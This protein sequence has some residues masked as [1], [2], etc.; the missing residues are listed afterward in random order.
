M[1]IPESH[2]DLLE[3]AA[4][5]HVATI[6][7]DGEPQSSPVWCGTDDE[8]HVIFSMLARRQKSKNL[9]RNPAIAMSAIDPDNAYRHLEIRGT[10]VSIEPDPDHSLIHTM[11]KKYLG[12]DAYPW[13]QP[14][15]ERVIV[16]V[17]AE[18]ATSM[19]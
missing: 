17:R 10:V 15:D 19:G 13:G 3:R 1:T 6:G 8:G 12:V 11:A 7:P 14:G 16:R 5:W 2:A 9:K 4:Y 18:H